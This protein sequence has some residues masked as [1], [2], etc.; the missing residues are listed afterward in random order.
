MR[1]YLASVLPDE[2]RWA[3]ALGLCDGVV[4]TPSVLAATVPHADPT[5]ILAE[6]AALTP[7]P[8]FASVAPLEAD[9]IVRDARALVRLAEHVVV[10]VPF[11]EDAIP[12]FP[13]LRAD[14]VRCAAT[15]VHS[16]AQGLLAAKAG[17]SHAVIAVDALEAVGQAAEV[18]VRDLRAALDRARLECDVVAAGPATAARFG[19]LAAAGADAAVVGPD[20]LRGLLQHPLT[21]RGVD[22]FLVD[23]SRRAKPRRAK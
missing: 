9:R 15:F 23:V 19:E 6:V 22:R 16:V 2:I 13:R 14:G 11:I 21:D 4:A 12:A 1:L 17:A 10:A 20:A 3:T 8:I 5:E 7:L 18:V